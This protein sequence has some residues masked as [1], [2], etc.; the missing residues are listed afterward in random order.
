MEFLQLSPQLPIDR[1]VAFELEDLL[2]RG[3][4]ALLVAPVQ[5]LDMVLVEQVG[6]DDRVQHFGLEERIPQTM[7]EVAVTLHQ[8]RVMEL[9][10]RRDLGE[11][12]D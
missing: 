12:L 9:L 3:D 8:V 4:D 5:L 2:V 10:D 7:L 1:H 6:L 11:H